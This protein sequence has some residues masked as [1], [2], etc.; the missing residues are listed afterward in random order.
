MPNPLL[1]IKRIIAAAVLVTAVAGCGS[2]DNDRAKTDGASPVSPGMAVPPTCAG[3]LKDPF[4]EGEG[5]VAL[6]TAS[7]GQMRCSLDFRGNSPILSKLGIASLCQHE[8]ASIGVVVN[9][10]VRTGR[11]R[12]DRAATAAVDNAECVER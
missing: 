5:R 11:W 12:Y 8:N 6:G 1:V 4:F 10:E 2:R 7:A 9:V 3:V